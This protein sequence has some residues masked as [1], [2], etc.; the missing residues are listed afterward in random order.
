MVT[1][2]DPTEE[3]KTLFQAWEWNVPADQK[4]YQRL[5]GAL[6]QYKEIGITTIWLPPACKAASGANGNGYDIYDLYDLGE[7]DQKGSV[8]TKFG[9]KD[10]LLTLC[11]KAKE[12]GIDVLFD[13]VLNHKAGADHT[14]K[15]MVVEVDQNDRTKEVGDPYEI[16]AWFGFDFPGRGD[17]YSKMKWHWEHFS[18]T[19][20]NAA[21]EKTAI[22][23]VQGDNKHWSQSVADEQGNADFMMFADI[24]YAHPEVCEDVIRWGEWVVKELGLSAFRL[25]AVQHF[26][27][28]FTTEFITN[29]EEKFGKN[30]I[31]IVG[32]YWDPEAQ[33][34]SDW[35]DQM[36]HKMS[37]FD[38]PLVNNFSNIS[39]EENADLRKVFD[40]SLVKMR[41]LDAVTLVTNHDTQTGQTVATP[42]EGFFKPLA[43]ALILLRNQGYPEVFYG[44]LYGTKK[45]DNPEGRVPH[46]SDLVLARKLYAYGEQDEYFNEANC[47]GFVRRGTSDHPSGL[48]CVMSNTGPG[49]IKMAVGDMHAGQKWT[50]VLGNEEGEVVIGPDGYGM[51]PCDSISV[52]VWV[53]KDAQGRDR[54]G[55]L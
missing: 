3:N 35:L 29:L 41:P 21:N 34:M 42:I 10:E 9:T 20:Y 6:D 40:G 11:K 15:C 24:D 46:V 50:D 2:T 38:S 7:F 39:K 31:F 36:N 8:G 55:K 1:G 28:R 32:E 4:H 49:E 5:I 16:E 45:E 33:V 48:A 19:D 23:K 43:Y 26:S 44:D 18:G 52:S 25:D 54:F 51:F 12:L 13:A 17:K 37:L 14:E 53:S 27:E 30:S 47:V 22:Y